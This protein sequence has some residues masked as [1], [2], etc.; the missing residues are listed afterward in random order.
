MSPNQIELLKARVRPRL[1]TDA[2]GRITYSARAN[3]VKGH[4]PK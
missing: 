3:A 4:V 2:T 1:P